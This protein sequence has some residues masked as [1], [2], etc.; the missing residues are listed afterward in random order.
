MLVAADDFGG[1]K[2]RCLGLFVVLA[3]LKANHVKAIPPILT[4]EEPHEI[5][6]PI[7][8]TEEEFER[9]RAYT[10][11]GNVPLG[12]FA[13]TAIFTAMGQPIDNSEEGS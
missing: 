1:R 3:H 13:R 10:D 11:Q 5:K 7:P 12:E 9:L 8:M 4:H 2:R 6:I